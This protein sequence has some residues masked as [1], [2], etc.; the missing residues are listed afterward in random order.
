MTQLDPSQ[1]GVDH[2]NV[3]SK[4]KTKLGRFLSNFYYTPFECADGKFAS[5]EGYW[6]WLNVPES[7]PRRDELRTKHGW[8]AKKLGRDLRGADWNTSD[9]FKNK[10]KDAI[11]IKLEINPI[12]AELLKNC[13]LPL[14]HY[15][16]YG[17]KV[18]EDHKSDWIIEYLET[19]K[20]A[21]K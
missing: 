12:P 5:I 4:A 19:F 14:K 9:D 18:V 8:E 11:R 3:Y 1:D 7:T 15:Y 10:I 21:N 2:L 17:D 16:V 6:Y 13:H 20:L